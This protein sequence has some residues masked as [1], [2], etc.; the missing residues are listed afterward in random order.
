MSVIADLGEGGLF[1]KGASAYY[2]GRAEQAK[3]W[4][5]RKREEECQCSLG[6]L[7]RFILLELWPWAGALHIQ[8]D[9]FLVS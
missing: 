7:T 4:S 1:G 2:A 8:D 9:Y 5:G 6:I 3:A